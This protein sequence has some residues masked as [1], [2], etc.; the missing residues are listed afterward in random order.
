MSLAFLHI[1]TMTF[2]F[3]GTQV[4]ET[5]KDMVLILVLS[6]CFCFIA[7]VLGPFLV[8]GLGVTLGGSQRIIESAGDQTWIWLCVK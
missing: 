5:E 8:Q 1:L 2:N 6:I 4:P 7:V 3:R